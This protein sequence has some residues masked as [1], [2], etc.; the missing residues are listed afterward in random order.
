MINIK[1][2]KEA[3]EVSL[4]GTLTELVTDTHFAL[5]AIY[6]S[7]KDENPA[8]AEI[9]KKFIIESADKLFLSSEEI[10]E[11]MKNKNSTEK[12]LNE[13]RNLKSKEM[14]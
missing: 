10:K 6:E 12:L 14:E 11:E 8:C 7:I 13:L 1:T 4:S 9:Y 2:H 5:I 3:T